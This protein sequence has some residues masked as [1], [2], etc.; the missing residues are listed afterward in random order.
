ML[1]TAFVLGAGLGTRLRPLTNDRPKPLV[2]V[3]GKPLI[4]FAFDH[5]IA[6]LGV[7]RFIVNTHHC[8]DAYAIAFPDGTY[9]GREIILRHE[10]VLLDS[11]GGI[12]NIRDLVAPDEPLAIYNGDILADFPLAGAWNAHQQSGGT[13]LVVRTSGE[14]KNITVDPETDLVVD[15]RGVLAGEGAS[16]PADAVATQFTGVYF[17]DA[18][19]LAGLP[20]AGD[21]YSIVN[22]WLDNIRR[23]TP[24]HAV[25]SDSGDWFDLGTIAALDAAHEFLDQGGFPLY[26]N[27]RPR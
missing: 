13:T 3:S 7:E 19:S 5:L 6:E 26:D 20:D 23:G 4:T 21:G 1:R 22:T 10:P 2:P 27:T 16:H 25:I 9:R 15:A 11:G 18:P 17:M 14:A 24:P 12:S 8:P